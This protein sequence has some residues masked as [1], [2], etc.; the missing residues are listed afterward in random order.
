MRRLRWKEC[1]TFALKLFVPG[2]EVVYDKVNRRACSVDAVR[3][4]MICSGV[5][6]GEDDGHATP[7][8]ANPARL[9]RLTPCKALLP[10]EFVSV[11]LDCGVKRARFDEDVIEAVYW[12]GCSSA[13]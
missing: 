8:E 9:P 4:G 3:L 12:H 13:A 10:T 5:A 6:L 7:G 11:E 1:Q 2:F